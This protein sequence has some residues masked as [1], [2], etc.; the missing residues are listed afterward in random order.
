MS[1]KRYEI[2]AIGCGKI[3]EIG[4][5]TG[6]QEMPDEARVRYVFDTDEEAARKAADRTGAALAED[7][8]R[9][10]DDEDVDIVAICTPPFAR[11]EYVAKACQAGKHL[12][13]EKPMARTVDDALEICR[14]IGRAGVKCFLPFMRT[15]NGRAR[16]LAEQVRSG[17]F[18]E[19]LAFVHAFLGTPYPWIPLDHWMHDEQFSGGA[20]FDYS[21]HFIELA[22]TCLGEAAAVL[23]GGAAVTGRVRSH[24][25]AT[26]LVNY[27]AG[28]FGEFTKAWSFPPG[29]DY[30]HQTTHI[31]CREAVIVLDKAP[32]AYTPGGK[33]E[34][35]VG[36][37]APSGRAESYRNLIAAIEEDAPLH[38]SELNGLRMNEILHAMER[39]RS[40]SS[41]EPVVVHPGPFG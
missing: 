37:E 11:V 39:S 6:L 24:D 28:R 9:I 15:M 41:R 33:R 12:M 5:W 38:A 23:Y 40:S 16:E 4:H 14:L 1:R 19:P 34:L 27:E 17:A 31:I 21:I 26:L 7:A 22:R 8:E 2:A 13:L 18:G 20:I 30:G 32:L 3:W 36:A 25:Q 10:F 29:C 35:D